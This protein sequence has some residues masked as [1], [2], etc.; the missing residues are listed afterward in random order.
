M[1]AVPSSVMS[2]SPSTSSY[3]VPVMRFPP[4]GTVRNAETSEVLF[5]SPAVGELRQVAI[6]VIL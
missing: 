5:A 4:P 1:R 3:S 6:A 2:P